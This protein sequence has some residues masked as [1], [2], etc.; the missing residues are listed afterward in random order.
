MI[1]VR[2]QNKRKYPTEAEL[3]RNDEYIA[4]FWCKAEER[5]V[6]ATDFGGHYATGELSIETNADLGFSE[7]DEVLLIGLGETKVRSISEASNPVLKSDRNARRG[8]PR[9]AWRFIAK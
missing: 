1:G 2:R 7:N 3:Y 6:V 9:Y 8:N 5:H 4:S